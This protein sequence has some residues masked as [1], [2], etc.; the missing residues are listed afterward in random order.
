MTNNNLFFLVKDQNGGFH[1][2]NR[3]D[4]LF[5]KS[6]GNY[7]QFTTNSGSFTTYGSL[8]SLQ[9]VLEP[10]ARF[11]QIHRSFIVNLEM[12]THLTSEAITINN[13]QVPIGRKFLD[14]LKSGF[15][16]TNLIIL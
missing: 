10:D 13:Q 4:I 9:T 11:M 16:Q 2:V 14:A 6:I 5:V 3:A 8:Q 1:K 7:L 15:V 12:V